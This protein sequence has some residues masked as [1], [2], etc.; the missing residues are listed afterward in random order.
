MDYVKK[1]WAYYLVIFIVIIFTTQIALYY[2]TFKNFDF[3]WNIFSGLADKDWNS[4]DPEGNIIDDGLEAKWG[5][6]GDFIGGILNPILG[7]ITI[8]LLLRA[9]QKDKIR[10][11][12]YRQQR[13]ID[14][15]LL[16]ID[17]LKDIHLDHV[18]NLYLIR[19]EG[20]SD[21]NLE[22]ITYVHQGAFFFTIFL[23]SLEI[24]LN[25]LR[26]NKNIASLE[27][28]QILEIGLVLLFRG[29]NRHSRI[30]IEN[31]YNNINY[32]TDILPQMK[33]VEYRINKIFKVEMFKGLRTQTSTYFRNLFHLI[34]TI[35][36]SN[37]ENKIKY[38]LV[39]DIRVILSSQE[40]VLLFLNSLTFFGKKWNLN[41]LIIK[42]KL[43]RNIG[44]FRLFA[45]GIDIEKEIFKLIDQS[46]FIDNKEEYKKNYFE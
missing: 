36:R 45:Q 28:T 25:N 32:A 19:M 17:K 37:L 6:F 8:I 34:D 4:I 9:H 14:I 35:D 42:Y 21:D 31:N 41:N 1:N 43:C 5:A 7:F 29:L 18:K 12:I 3:G 2:A 11:G 33:R 38:E 44:D 22:Q 46:T 16:R 40:Q 13:E 26:K 20:Q 24:L 39:K 23:N 10:D 27:E 30:F 15:F